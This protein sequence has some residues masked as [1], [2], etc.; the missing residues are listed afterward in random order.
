MLDPAI[1]RPGRFDI[2]IHIPLPDLAVHLD[3]SALIADAIQT[4]KKGDIGNQ[5]EEDANW[6]GR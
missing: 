5:N 2:S 1:M 4:G 3:T 6:F